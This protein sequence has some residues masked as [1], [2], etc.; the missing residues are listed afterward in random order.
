MKGVNLRMAKKLN[1]VIRKNA[2]I[3]P[4]GA[5]PPKQNTV[6]RL[7]SSSGGNKHGRVGTGVNFSKKGQKT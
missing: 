6:E 7:S 1:K 4:V 3:T 2:G 5:C